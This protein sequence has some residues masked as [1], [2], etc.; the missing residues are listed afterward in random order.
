MTKVV[1]I[2]ATGSVGRVARQLF[3]EKTNDELTLFS[4]RPERLKPI[5]PTREVSVSGDVMKAGELDKAISGQDVVFASLTGNL[6]KMAKAIVESMQRVGVKRLIFIT[7][8]GIYN[9]IPASVGSS[10]N[11]RSN[12]VLQTYRDAADVIEASGLDY[13]IVRPGWFDS[14]NDTD[15][16]I[17][18]KGEPFGGHDV[19]RKSI[20]D[21]VL[22]LASDPNLYVRE[23]VGINRPE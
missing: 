16:E 2:G 9:E 8:M 17:T 21:L 13:T 10:G 4:R 7:S 22:R 12:P 3:L 15:Y 20:A 6:G 19:S 14:S 23:S 5:D 18:V 11:L 1:I